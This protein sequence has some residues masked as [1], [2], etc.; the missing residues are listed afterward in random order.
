MTR[1]AIGVAVLGSSLLAMLAACGGDSFKI[2][3]ENV[4]PGGESPESDPRCATQASLLGTHPHASQQPT[5]L[6]RTISD[7]RGWKGRLYFAYGDFEANTG[8]IFITT[9]DPKTKTW[10]EHPIAYKESGTGAM[11]STPAFYTHDIQRFLPIG[12]SL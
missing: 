9:F 4:V 10:D 8:P 12:D 3:I 6:G 1:S 7:T 5:E 11:K 2:T